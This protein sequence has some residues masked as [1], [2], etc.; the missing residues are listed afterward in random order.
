MDYQSEGKCKN[1]VP[2]YA[3]YTGDNAEK[4]DKSTMMLRSLVGLCTVRCSTATSAGT[5]ALQYLTL[6]YWDSDRLGEARRL[7]YQIK[8]TR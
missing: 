3:R 5:V 8:V 4:P 7:G 6:P 2:R 1:Q